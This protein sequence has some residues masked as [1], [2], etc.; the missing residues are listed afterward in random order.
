MPV[1]FYSILDLMRQH[2]LHFLGRQTNGLVQQKLD[3]SV[4]YVV[5]GADG[6]NL[7]LVD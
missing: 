2:R 4:D 5:H 7:A 1:L 3:L 6:G